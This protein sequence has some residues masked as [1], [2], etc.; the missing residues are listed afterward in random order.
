[1]VDDRH[2]TAPERLID[3]GRGVQLCAQSFGDESA[4]P[5]V[6]IAGLGQQLLSWPDDLCGHLLDR[7][8]RVVRFDNRDIGRSSLATAPAP[9]PVQLLR[10]RFS[11]QQYDLGDMA[12]DTAGLLRGLEID[13]AHVVGVSMG[14][15]IAQ[16]LAARNPEAVQSLVSIMSN[17]G[18]RGAGGPARS[19][20]LRLAK[21]PA[22]DREG[23][24]QRTVEMFRHIGSHG[25]PFDEADVR[26]RA[27][28]AYERGHDP[29]GV[30]RQLAAIMKSG[31]RTAEVRR[32]A[33]P[34][35]VIH[36][37]RDRM[38]DPSG[39]VATAA[40]IAGARHETIHGM[41]H[42]LPAGAR[43]QLA[44]LIAEHVHASRGVT[45]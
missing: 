10:R 45:A 5:V 37:D 38:V 44:D 22:T 6:L 21:P 3:V 1:M 34:T 32:I 24:I 12:A 43:K 23:A 41:G 36:G 25:F 42:D 7:G 2:H 16:T 30:G 40:A 33:A 15:M 35:L 31:D 28:I 20:W 39:G 11:P 18:A 14:G 19:T 29:R 27:E 8:L 4:P 9:S 17:T 13:R 26:A